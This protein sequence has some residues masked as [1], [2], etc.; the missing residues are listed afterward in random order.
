MTDVIDQAQE[1]EEMQRQA[2]INN[3]SSRYHYTGM[4]WNCCE[5]LEHGSFCPGG[6]CQED[7]EK[8]ER[9]K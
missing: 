6:E 3:R 8:R 4:C 7:F 2:A 1:L 9:M 5:P